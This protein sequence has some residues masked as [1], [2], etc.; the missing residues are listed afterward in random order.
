MYLAVTTYNS[1]NV[2]LV[3]NLGD[4][5]NA[6]PGAPTYELKMPEEREVTPGAA[7]AF[8]TDCTLLAVALR[9][10]RIVVFELET[11][12]VRRIFRVDGTSK[13]VLHLSYRLGLDEFVVAYIWNVVNINGETGEVTCTIDGTIKAI[14]LQGDRILVGQHGFN[15]A[16][17][18]SIADGN[19]LNSFGYLDA[20]LASTTYNSTASHVVALAE[21]QDLKQRWI[22]VWDAANGRLLYCHSDVYV[23]RWWPHCGCCVDPSLITL[24]GKCINQDENFV[25]S[26]NIEAGTEVSRLAVGNLYMCIKDVQTNHI[27]IVSGKTASIIDVGSGMTLIC[28]ELEHSIYKVHF[29]S[30]NG[31]I[32]L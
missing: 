31:V 10:R 11:Q 17:E 7:M 13:L 9:E 22:V 3:W 20:T 24:V 29:Q 5:S 18:Y 6:D 19:R 32:L 15:G 28:L 8:S 27:G 2:V 21:L 12:S 1:R 4:C 25:V 23:Y 30:R 16:H 26:I 14:T